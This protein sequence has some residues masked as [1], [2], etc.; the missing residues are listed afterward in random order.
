M[1][2]GEGWGER[3]EGKEEERRERGDRETFNAQPP[4]L[5]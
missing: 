5:Q 2:R 1:Q 4:N 3:A